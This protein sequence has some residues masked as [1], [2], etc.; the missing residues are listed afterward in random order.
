[1]A[2]ENKRFRNVLVMGEQVTRISKSP[3]ACEFMMCAQ[4]RQRTYAHALLS[5]TTTRAMYF[6]ASIYKPSGFKRSALTKSTRVR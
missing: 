3:P 6:C 4:L 1:M 5:V 2:K